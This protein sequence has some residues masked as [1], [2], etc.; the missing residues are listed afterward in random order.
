MPEPGAPE[1]ETV[2]LLESEPVPLLESEPVPLRISETV[3]QPEADPIAAPTPTAG[4]EPAQDAAAATAAPPM[5]PAE[6]A[7][8][9]KALFP[10]LFGGAAKPLKLRIQT[11]IQQRAPGVFTR[12]AL[13]AFLHRHTGSTGYLMAITR[14]GQRFDLDGN[15][16]EAVNDEHRA[17][18]A[19]ELTRRR[20][21]QDAQ[22]A[23]EQDQRA[24]EQTQRRNR[25]GLLRDFQT[26][27]L[28]R[29]NFCV[30]KVVDPAELDA[31]LDRARREFEED[32]QQRPAAFEQRPQ[33]PA[34]PRPHPSRPPRRP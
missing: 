12:R 28:T 1:S 11:D 20:A 22:R 5:T 33:R 2:P 6:C 4:D 21:S 18:A 32:A 24:L 26:T 29:A 3:P 14:V 9:L 30:L 10:A 17:A 15:A 23:L 31:L 27:T 7:Q 8:Q 34:P 25:A 16:V 13:S 19:A